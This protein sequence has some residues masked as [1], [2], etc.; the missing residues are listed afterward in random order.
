MQ[1][2]YDMKKTS[3]EIPIGQK[4]TRNGARYEVVEFKKSNGFDCAVCRWIGGEIPS[5]HI[6]DVHGRRVMILDSIIND[7]YTEYLSTRP[8]YEEMEKRLEESM[9]LINKFRESARTYQSDSIK[10]I[11]FSWE[12]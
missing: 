3:F 1:F 8:S 9:L 11:K 4:F 5:E 12:N 7:C 6:F 10:V 2:M